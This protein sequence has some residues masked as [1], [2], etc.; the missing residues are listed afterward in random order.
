M[1]SRWLARI[2]FSSPTTRSTSEPY[3]LRGDLTTVL[4]HFIDI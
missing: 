4:V 1:T 3:S 2:A